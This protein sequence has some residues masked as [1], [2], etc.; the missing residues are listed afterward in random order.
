[1]S[2]ENFGGGACVSRKMILMM[3]IE[4]SRHVVGKRLRFYKST[5]ALL[6]GRFPAHIVPEGR[7]EVS[8]F[9]AI[10]SG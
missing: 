1:M 2:P 4:S 7:N 9:S 5:S 8:D 6:N 10:L 3:E